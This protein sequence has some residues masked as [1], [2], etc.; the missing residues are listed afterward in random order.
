MDLS[1][2]IATTVE[3]NKVPIPIPILPPKTNIDI[4]EFFLTPLFK[5]IKAAACG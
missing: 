1:P 5:L 2:P 3:I 4:P